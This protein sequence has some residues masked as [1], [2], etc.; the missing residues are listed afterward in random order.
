MLACSLGKCETKPLTTHLQ[1]SEPDSCV[2]TDLRG[3]PI[4]DG[5]GLEIVKLTFVQDRVV[6]L[7]S[8]RIHCFKWIG[9]V[10]S[11]VFLGF[12]TETCVVRGSR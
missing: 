10:L 12:L 6:V 7:R 3:N 11:I 1:H 9:I 4:I 5:G 2:P 8:E